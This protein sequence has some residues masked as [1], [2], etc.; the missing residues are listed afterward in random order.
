MRERI[1]PWLSASSLPCDTYRLGLPCTVSPHMYRSVTATCRSRSPSVNV[2]SAQLQS[3]LSGGPNRA[4]RIVR[5]RT[6]EKYFKNGAMVS[7]SMVR[8]FATRGEINSVTNCRKARRSPK[9]YLRACGGWSTAKEG[10]RQPSKVLRLRQTTTN[11]DLESIPG[12]AAREERA[13]L[14][15]K[16][17]CPAKKVRLS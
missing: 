12:Q 10:K 1:A 15:G 13:R 8:L 6:L 14:Q 16:I 2:P 17:Q 11:T 7:I 3:I 4:T 9:G 5:S